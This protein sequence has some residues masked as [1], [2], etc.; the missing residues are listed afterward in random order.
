MTAG[1]VYTV[2]GS[3]AGTGRL[4]RPGN[5]TPAASPLL[6]QPGRAMAVN[7]SGPVHRRHRQLP[8]RGDRRHDRDAVGHLDDRRRHVHHRRHAPAACGSA[9]ATTAWPPRS[10]PER[11][12]Q[13]APRRRH[14]QQRPVHRR[15]RQQPDPGDRRGRR[16]EWGQSDD[17]HHIYTVAG[18]S[19]GTVGMSGNG[20]AATAALLSAPKGVT[21]DGSAT[22]SSPTP[23]TAGSQEVPVSTGS[24]WGVTVDDRRSTC[25]PWPGADRQRQLHDRQRQQVARP[26]QPDFPELGPRSA[27]ATL[28]IADTGNNR[29]QEVAGTAHTRVRPDDDR[30]LRLHDRGQRDRRRPATPATAARPPRR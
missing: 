24:Y 23:P 30:E 10:R 5:G 28:Y 7:S 11:A 15:R 17:R 16:T 21:I 27:T 26:V 3:P 13:P 14:S 29:I 2:A 25:T 8:D 20:T 4:H 9:A 19:T 22:C 1:D 18:S 6:D 12:D